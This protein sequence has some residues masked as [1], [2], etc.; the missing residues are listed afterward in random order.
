[1]RDNNDLQHC[2]IM[3][4]EGLSC[5]DPYLINAGGGITLDCQPLGDGYIGPGGIY[6]S[7]DA[8]ED[9]Y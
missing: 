1:M 6:G 4:F 7:Y 2:H 5:S 8:H 9:E 3:L